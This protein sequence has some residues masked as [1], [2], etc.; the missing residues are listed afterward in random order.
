MNTREQF[1]RYL[2]LKKLTEDPLG[3]TFRAGML[4][5]GGME[6]VV[7]LRVFNGQG[8]DGGRLWQATRDRAR[9]QPALKSPNIGEGVD[10]GELQGIPFVAYDYTSGKNLATLEEQ[11][12]KKRNPIPAEHALLIT[13]RIALALAAANETRL[14]GERLQHG[15]VVPHLAMISN[16]GETRLLGFEV[17][18]GLRGF[19]ANPVVRQHFGRYLAPEVLAGQG[20]H[21]SDDVF[22]LGAILLELLTGRPLVPPSNVSGYGALIDQSTL[23]VEGTPIPESLAGLLKRSL[24]GREQRLSDVNEWHKAL[25]SW[26]FEGQY[27]PTTFNLAFYMHNLFRQEIER[28]SQEIEV[29]KTLPLPTVNPADYAPPATPDTAATPIQES[30]GVGPPPAPPTGAVPTTGAVPVKKKGGGGLW[31]GLAAFLLVVV[32]ALATYYFVIAEREAPEPEP[33]AAAPPPVIEEPPPLPPGP[34]EEELAAKQQAID[35]LLEQKANAMEEELR[36]QFDARLEK[37]QDELSA[38]QDAA[39]ERQRL[40]DEREA[41]RLAAEE[42]ARI[43]AEEEAAKKEAEAAQEALAKA[44]AEADDTEQVAATPPPPPEVAP[45]PPKPAAPQVRRGDLVKPGTPGLVPAVLTRSPR[46]RFPEMARRLNKSGAVVTVRVL[47]DENGNVTDTEL[48][49]KEVG[50]G[51]DDAALQAAKSAKYRAAKVGNVPVK[52]WGTLRI[53]F[54]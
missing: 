21:R 13:E 26:M 45:P 53:E 50:F 23:A 49:N 38:A 44:E 47:I 12:T 9:I 32:G 6:R 2:L 8:L 17:G 33:V 25:N 54:Q 34:T 11:A 51:F 3:E 43:A 5:P 15:F 24:V 30:T 20:P 31:I 41:Q 52:M 18:P 19:A 7:L 14:D 16:E 10:M 1:G 22:S 46:A 27:N 42:A 39:A 35:D 40:L 29:E 48:A 36:A 37:M 28:E 4:G